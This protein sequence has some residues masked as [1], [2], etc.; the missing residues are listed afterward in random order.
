MSNCSHCHR[1]CG[2]NVPL[3]LA[4]KTLEDAADYVPPRQGAFNLKSPAL[5]F[6]GAGAIAN[7]PSHDLEGFGENAAYRVEYP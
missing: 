5:I 6:L 3:L 2:G 1:R 4:N 7:L